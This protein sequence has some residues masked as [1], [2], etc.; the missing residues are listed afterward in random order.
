MRSFTLLR[1]YLPKWTHTIM[2]ES[3]AEE[4]EAAFEA[5][6]KHIHDL[7]YWGQDATHLLI[8]Y[9][10]GWTDSDVSFNRLLD[11]YTPDNE[12]TVSR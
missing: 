9:R 11:Y 8:G 3:Y 4:R 10:Q 6:W 5:Y 7:G 12:D 1:R 2:P